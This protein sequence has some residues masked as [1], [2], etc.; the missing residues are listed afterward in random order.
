MAVLNLI[1]S[2]SV[3]KNITLVGMGKINIHKINMEQ[4][5]FGGTNL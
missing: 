1:I 3:G 2:N 5:N 4:M